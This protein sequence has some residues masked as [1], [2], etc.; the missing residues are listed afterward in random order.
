MIKLQQISFCNKVVKNLIQDNDKQLFI[1]KLYNNYQI[2]INDKDYIIL[3]KEYADNLKKNLHYVTTF[4]SGNQY[5]MYLTTHNDIPLCLFIDRKIKNGYNFPRILSVN[6]EF[7]PKLY[8][9]DNLFGGELIKDS[10]SNWTF[11]INNLYVYQGTR[12]SLNIISKFNII[13]NILT[14]HLKI[15]EKTQPCHLKVK[16]LFCANQT[17]MII[18]EYI[19]RLKYTNK[20]LIF[21]PDNSKYSNILYLFKINNQSNI[22]NNISIDK[23][24]EKKTEHKNESDYSDSSLNNDN[25]IIQ[26]E[27]LINNF[28]NKIIFKFL[29]KNTDNPDIYQLYSN[30]QKKSFLY[31]FA[32][33]PNLKCSKYISK[34]FENNDNLTIKC[35]YSKNF[36]KWEPIIGSHT[37]E[38]EDSIEN[39]IENL[40]SF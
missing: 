40:K 18:D 21:Y 33:I 19:P 6:Y 34:L 9:K 12:C 10:D 24:L 15:N 28:D 38:K 7:D 35:C 37:T 26:I 5:F 39:I 22:Q 23:K 16:K 3:K 2:S 17:K 4:S 11:M 13:Y 27:K 30:F 31:G 29:V 25:V 8:D 20:G 1:N 14:K 36:N 32:H